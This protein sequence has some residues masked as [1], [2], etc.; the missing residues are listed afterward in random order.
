MEVIMTMSRV[1]LTVGCAV[2]TAAIICV[3]TVQ[4]QQAPSQPEARLIVV[5][6]GSVRVAPEHAQVTTGVTTK[7]NTVKQATDANSKL[8]AA[9]T[10]ALVQSGIAQQDIQTSRFSIQ[11]L[12]TNEPRAEPKLAGYSV[13]NQVTLKIREI[14]KIGDI[15]DRLITVGVTDVSNIAFLVSDPSKA[16]DH[17]REAAIGDARRKAEVYAHAAGLRVGQIVWI[18]ED[19]GAIPSLNARSGGA[20][21]PMAAQVPIASG[22]DILRVRV[23]VG[24]AVTR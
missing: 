8:M 16:L 13:S 19:S 14:E 7:A 9:V 10:A 17:A 11:P 21:P 1:I 24:F 22:E 12:Y 3:P 23:S 4:A 20:P 6:E 2:L 5:G 18:T 15:L